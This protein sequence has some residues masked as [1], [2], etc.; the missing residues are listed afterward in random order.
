MTA[1]ES[2]RL[3]SIAIRRPRSTD[4]SGIFHCLQAYNVQI[5]RGD[6][7][8]ADDDF[9]ADHIMTVRNAISH[10]DLS[11][12]CWI[13]DDGDGILGFCCWDWRDAAKRSAKTVLIS[14]LDNARTRGVGKLLQQRRQDEM[15]ERNAIDVHTWSDDPRAV[16]WYQRTFG[17]QLLGHEPIRH[18]LHRFHF[19]GKGEVWAIHRG[20]IE[21]DKL[22]HLHLVF[23]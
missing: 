1:T 14:V 11:D 7:R 10:I 19:D 23:S 22:A 4:L 17:Y 3:Q 6:V 8:C 2:P 18:S 20:F 16:K 15:R 5:L 13:A 12:K 21:Q 9:E